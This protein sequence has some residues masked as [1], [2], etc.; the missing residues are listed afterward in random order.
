MARLCGTT[1]VV[2]FRATAAPVGAQRVARTCS[3]SPRLVHWAA[4]NWLYG[5]AALVAAGA[6]K[7]PRLEIQERMYHLAETQ[8]IV[9]LK[10]LSYGAKPFW[11]RADRGSVLG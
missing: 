7:S 10:R 6:R 8:W 9:I 4:T 3:L 1:K 2:P 11:R 5:L